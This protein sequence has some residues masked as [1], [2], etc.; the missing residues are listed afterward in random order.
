MFYLENNREQLYQ[1][2]SNQ[3]IIV[4]DETITHIHY[5]NRTDSEALVVEVYEEGGKRF[6]NIPNILLQDAWNICVY[7]YCNGYYTKQSKL[8]K[9]IKRSKPATYVYTETEKV[10]W[11]ELE[12][13]IKAE[14]VAMETRVLA[15]A[16]N[17]LTQCANVIKGTISG[18][19]ALVKDV[20]PIPHTLEITTEPNANVT[21]WG[22]NLFDVTPIKGKTVS[23]NGGTLTCDENGYI[24]GSGTPTGGCA[25]A[26][27]RLDNLPKN[28]L[29]VLSRHGESTN[30][31]AVI[32]LKDKN[33]NNLAYS[34]VDS[35]KAQAS[36]KPSNYP[37]FAYATIEVKRSGNNYEMSGGMY[38][39]LE[40]GN[41]TTDYEPALPPITYTA[42]EEGVVEGAT[43]ISPSLTFVADKETTIK[44][45]RDTNKV[46]EELTQAIIS[47]GGNV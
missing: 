43:S 35:S 34:G 20:A 31:A 33:G 10:Q 8:I 17:T 12:A 19:E 18:T 24:S 42:N 5:C 29:M 39:Q 1:W 36:C 9:V 15:I 14:M 6:A 3:R 41:Q 30:L 40:I 38:L 13:E 47:L 46:I 2:D 28:R 44:Y 37:N 25:F 32:Y 23:I 11:A 26:A 7:A 45:N 22:K 27:Y 16:D 21:L 4:D